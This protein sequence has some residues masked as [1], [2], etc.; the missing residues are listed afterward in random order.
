MILI[1]SDVHLAYDRYGLLN[2]K[3][4]IL[5]NIIVEYGN[6]ADRIYHAGDGHD[7]RSYSA[8]LATLEA[9]VYNLLKDKRKLFVCLGNHD[10]EKRKYGPLSP[11]SVASGINIV[12][13]DH[14]IDGNWCLRGWTDKP[15]PDVKAKYFLGHVNLRDEI[16]KGFSYEELERT[17]FER[18]YLGDL[19]QHKEV[20][21]VVSIGCL[22]PSSFRDEGVQG[23]FIVFGDS[24]SYDFVRYTI[25]QQRYPIFKTIEITPENFDRDIEEVTNNVVRVRVTCPE[26]WFTDDRREK[27][28]QHILDLKPWYFAGFIVKEYKSEKE[29]AEKSFSDDPKEIIIRKAR[30][31]G[32]TEKQLN[33]VLDCI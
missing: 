20:G 14:I 9:E 10:G 27:L 19:H 25:P 30:Q 24:P 32:W 13:E 17:G 31:D 28:R 2:R 5:R 26:K 33:M 8:E 18:I 23:G 3:L 29:L 4:E 12:G 11:Y 1:I 7:S 22:F 15:L 21:K 16:G 6:E